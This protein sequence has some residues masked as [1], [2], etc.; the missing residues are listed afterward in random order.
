MNY[1][2]IVLFIIIIIILAFILVTNVRNTVTYSTAK[3][4]IILP[5]SSACT[6]NADLIPHVDT[7]QNV[8][9]YNN[10]VRTGAYYVQTA[11]PNPI[12]GAD[13]IPLAMSVIPV[14]NNYITV[15][16]EFCSGGYTLLNSSTIQCNGETSTTSPQSLLANACVAI[17][18]P[19]FPNGTPCLG[20][21]LPVA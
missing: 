16:R 2:L 3:D 6:V 18:E 8:C 9:C 4:T 13:P 1:P 19:K 10:N 15:C 11:G 20:S 14:A 12:P 5:A 17:S 7:D 21:A